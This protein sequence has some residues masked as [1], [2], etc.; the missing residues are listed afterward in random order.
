MLKQLHAHIVSELQQSS[1][2]DTIF[3]IT[4][5]IFNLI[6]LGINSGIAG[7]AANSYN[8]NASDDI[9]LVVFIVMNLLINTIAVSALYLG[10]ST[11]NNLLS[12]LVTMYTDNNIAKYYHPSLLKIT[13]NAICYSLPSSF[14]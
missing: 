3:V 13:A 12:G 2:T 7:E 4:A 10:R 9:L 5:I 6:V 11:R 1:R 14:V 8:N